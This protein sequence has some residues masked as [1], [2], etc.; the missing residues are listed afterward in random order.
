M[1][2]SRS[3][4]IAFVIGAAS[5]L[6]AALLKHPVLDRYH[7][8]IVAD[9]PSKQHIV[10]ALV[11]LANRSMSRTTILKMDP[12]K[13]FAGLELPLPQIGTSHLL[14]LFYLS[15]SRDRSLAAS[16][17]RGHNDLMFERIVSIAYKIETLHSLIVVTDIGLV[18]D[19][20]GKFS[21]NWIDVGQTP[22]DEV[23]RSSIAVELSCLKE[24]ELPIVRIRVGL[25]LD[26]DGLPSFHAYWPPASEVFIGFSSIIRRLPRLVTIPVAAAKG[27]LAPVTPADFAAEVMLLATENARP[28]NSAIHAVMDPAPTIDA[29]LE[30]AGRRIGGARLRAG[31][32][33][34]KVA[35]LGFV[36]GFREL[37][38]RNAD[39][40]ASWWTPH[41]YCLSQNRVDT[42]HLKTLLP[43]TFEFPKLR[44]LEPLI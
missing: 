18:G 16:V 29:M 39:Q 4:R 24:N 44:A 38:R 20:P 28:G 32:P 19:Y 37:A 43:A 23:D 10:R 7:H 13:P 8:L 26:P 12:R 22:F 25:V 33:I 34:D 5:P 11:Q 1:A 35:K 17:V 15:H 30:M 2:K 36:P 41:R 42:T 21:E 27:A 9:A 14:D 40:L 3:R 31:L 6:G